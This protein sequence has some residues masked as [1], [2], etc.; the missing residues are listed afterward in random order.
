[1]GRRKGSVLDDATLA[2]AVD[3]H[4]KFYNAEWARRLLV[5]ACGRDLGQRIDNAIMDAIAQIEAEAKRERPC[6]ML[7]FERAAVRNGVR[8]ELERRGFT[9]S[10]STTRSVS[11]PTTNEDA[12]VS[13][14]VRW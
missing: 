9:C 7:D 5:E 13:L 12:V 6:T 10:L 1:M 4:R 14:V 3:Q 11:S 2:N 8:A